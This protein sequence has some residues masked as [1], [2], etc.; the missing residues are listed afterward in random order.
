MMLTT[1][2]I[3]HAIDLAFIDR[4]DIKAFI[5]PP[6]LQ[7]RYN[8]L[9]SSFCELQ[10]VGIVEE[11]EG[12]TVYPCTY[13]EVTLSD[14]ENN[15]SGSKGLHL[16]KRLLQVAQSCEGLSGRILRKLPFLAHATSSVPGSCSADIFIDK[17]QSAVQKELEDR[18]NMAE[19]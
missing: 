13:N 7:G 11:E 2:N 9:H 19:S 14:S 18:N 17:L 16:G 12:D 10:R 6:S 15:D 3:T 4:A 8:M 1:S 5:G